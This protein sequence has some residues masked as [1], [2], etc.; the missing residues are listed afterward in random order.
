MTLAESLKVQQNLTAE[1]ACESALVQQPTEIKH[2]IFGAIKLQSKN[3]TL[4]EE[5][6]KDIDLNTDLQIEDYSNLDELRI[7]LFDCNLMLKENEKTN[8]TEPETDELTRPMFSVSSMAKA[9]MNGR[10]EG[11]NS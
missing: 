10:Q 8:E 4:M 7:I 11:A 1:S 2:H 3:I 6:S 9:H 5:L